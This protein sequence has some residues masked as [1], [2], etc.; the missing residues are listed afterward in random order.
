[1]EVKSRQTA[2]TIAETTTAIR[3]KEANQL[4]QVRKRA[5]NRRI[6]KHITILCFNKHKMVMLQLGYIKQIK[7]IKKDKKYKKKT[8]KEKKIKLRIRLLSKWGVAK[9]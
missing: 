3:A 1:M 6:F 2:A 5:A 7:N 8:C 4:L 9:W